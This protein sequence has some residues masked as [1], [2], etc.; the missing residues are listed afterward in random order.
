MLKLKHPTNP[1][2][3]RKSF[4]LGSNCCIQFEL[5]KI[6]AR[7]KF[8]SN[9]DLGRTLLQVLESPRSKSSLNWDLKHALP[10]PHSKSSLNW[11]LECA[12]PEASLSFFF[13]SFGH[14]CLR[15][16]WT[17]SMFSEPSSIMGS[18]LGQLED[19]WRDISRAGASSP[20]CCMYFIF[21]LGK[22]C[23][24]V[25]GFFC[26]FGWTRFSMGFRQRWERVWREDRR[27]T[28]IT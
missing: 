23:V 20:Q 22:C 21:F 14:P 19:F 12:S 24:F 16:F 26:V 2:F 4:I 11:D 7:C 5:V 9:W 3:C 27:W 1:L 28:G 13:S 6:S 10:T 18:N 17:S 25:E 15:F 8:S